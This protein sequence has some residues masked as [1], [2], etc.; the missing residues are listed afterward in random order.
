MPFHEYLHLFKSFHFFLDMKIASEHDLLIEVTKSSEEI[1]ITI[2]RYLSLRQLAQ[3]EEALTPNDPVKRLMETHTE[4]KERIKEA[5]KYRE[6]R[7]R[8]AANPELK[9]E[10][11]RRY[12]QRRKTRT[13]ADLFASLVDS[14]EFFASNRSYWENLI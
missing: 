10:R 9:R 11:R 5:H 6:F 1:M 4:T 3:L 8:E 14:S 13:R 2:L 7:R 12:R